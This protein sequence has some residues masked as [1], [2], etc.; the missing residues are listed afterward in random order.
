MNGIR[1]R[2]E[3]KP[4]KSF[5]SA[6]V[7]PSSAA[8][9]RSRRRSRRRSAR[10][11]MTSTSFSTGTGLK[12]CMPITWSGRA[13][14]GGERGDRD[15]GR[16]RGEDRV[17][18]A[19]PRRRARKSSSFTAASSTT[20]S[21]IRSAATSSSTGVD[22]REHLVRVG[23]ALLG[24]LLEALAASPSSAALDR[25]RARRRGARRAGPRRRRPG[26]SR[27]PSGRRRRRGRA[28]TLIGQATVSRGSSRRR[29]RCRIENAEH[30][31]EDD[32]PDHDLDRVPA[33]L[34]ARRRA[35][36]GSISTQHAVASQRAV[37]PVASRSP[38]ASSSHERLA[39]RVASR[40]GTRTSTVRPTSPL[41]ALVDLEAVEQ[42]PGARPRRAARP[43]T[44]PTKATSG[45][46]EPLVERRCSGRCRRTAPEHAASAATPRRVRARASDLD[47]EGV[48]LAAAGADRREAEPAA[49]AAELVDQRAD[50]PR[51]PR[52]RSDGR[53]RPRRR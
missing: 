45:V 35:A 7:L 15:R 47:Q 17:R 8:S 18:R 12:K 43:T 40:T 24:E 23:A 25:A 21:I 11:R 26:R 49:V 10:A 5:A 39:S 20:A 33:R 31:R 30:E 4:G 32:E 37:E 50:D 22:A 9:R 3:T 42:L 36:P 38:S 19:A 46:V 13:V 14:D 53:A 51:R 28:R 2:F 34:V 41:T 52:R 6:G 27:R 1:I 44:R 29:S 16:V 48:A